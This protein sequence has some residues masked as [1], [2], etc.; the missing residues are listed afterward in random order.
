MQPNIEIAIPAKVSMVHT[1]LKKNMDETTIVTRRMALPIACDTVD[2]EL[3]M[4]KEAV[5]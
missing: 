3:R 5:L 1:V 4:P 2:N